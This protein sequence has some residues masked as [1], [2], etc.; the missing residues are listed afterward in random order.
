MSKILDFIL[1]SRFLHL[2]FYIFNHKNLRIVASFSKARYEADRPL[3]WITP[4]LR[5]ALGIRFA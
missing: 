3:S 4:P 2:K 5:K 1:Q